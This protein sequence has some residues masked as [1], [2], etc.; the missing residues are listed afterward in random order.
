MARPENIGIKAM[1]I[2]FPKHYVAQEDLEKYDGV[3]PGKYTIGLAQN[4]MAFVDGREDINSISLT[5]L[6]NLMEKYG[7]PFESIGRLE[8]GSESLVDKSKA[9]KTT[10]MR[11]FEERGLYDVEGIDSKNACY[12][13]TAA[14]LNS[15]AW[16]ESSSWDG[17]D[18]IVIAGDI[19]VYEAGPARPTGGAGVVAMLIGP[20]APMV[21]EP[22]IRCSH[23]EDVFDFYKPDMDSEYPV[24]DGHLSNACYLRALESCYGGYAK[25]FEKV[26]GQKF[27]LSLA[28][29]A[30]F[31]APYNKLVQKSFG[32]YLLEDFKRNPDHP[33]KEQL[34][35]FADAAGTHTDRELQKALVA[36][37][38]PLYQNMVAPT[39][40]I[41]RE[42]GNSYCGSLY[43]GL[44]SLITE[45]ADELPDKR[46]LMFSYGSGLAATLFS[47]KV[48]G[49][50]TNIRDT[51]RVKD[52]LAARER[53]DPYDFARTL[54]IREKTWNKFN[55][56]PQESVANLFPNTYYLKNTDQLRR[57][58]Y[59]RAFST[60]AR[61][62]QRPTA[63]S[64]PVPRAL[65]P[66]LYRVQKLLTR[67]RK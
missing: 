36:A 44:L 61:T 65:L 10:L 21:V 54:E 24:V 25:K 59:A 64:G 23:Y 11:L 43:A 53:V 66:G 5:V 3:S 38:K 14:L 28:D 41:T 51:T 35:P 15:L 47:I 16:I 50:V 9:I 52:R 27:D 18:A 60:F 62:L 55:Y 46:V 29:Y 34:A 6:H 4:N 67:L 17:R 26:F 8:V 7:I 22:K 56:E 13:G 19:A 32:Y 30:V 42:C 58:H 63:A 1:E 37:S 39:E 45:K 48:Q 2:Y 57:R 33:L 40:L 49:D 12:G 20:N 31:H